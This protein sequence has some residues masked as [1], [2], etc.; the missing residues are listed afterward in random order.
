MSWHRTISA[1]T[2]LGVLF[3]VAVILCLPGIQGI[4]RSV[5]QVGNLSRFVQRAL[6]PDFSILP[7]VARA[8]LETAQ[9]AVVATAAAAVFALPLAILA[10]R[11]LLGRWAWPGRL[12]LAAVR[13]V[14]S[15]VWALVAVAVVGPS[16]L[17]GA[18]ALTAYSVAYLGTFGADDLDA[19]DLA[20]P[21]TLRAHG[22]SPVQAAIHGLLPLLT[23]R[24]S[25]HLLWMVEYNL[26]SAAI[27]GYVGAGG[28]GVLLHQYQEYGQWPRFTTVLLA[29]LAVVL[30]LDSCGAWL[31]RSDQQRSEKNQLSY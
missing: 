5:D 10:S 28:I 27:I 7:E 2:A 20:I 17:A 14:P 3:L 13:S 6:P 18:I 31:R 4:G 8:L 30:I 15:L 24:L 29:V 1:P 23:A 22:A 16:T 21:R 25:S 11:N 26:R 19:A 9:I 12:L